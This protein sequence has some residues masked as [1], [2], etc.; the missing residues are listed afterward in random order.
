MGEFRMGRSRAAASYPEPRFTGLVGPFARNVAVGPGSEVN[1]APGGTTISWVLIESTGA[2]GTNVPI[3]PK[4]AIASPSSSNVA[5]EGVIGLHNIGVAAQDVTV[6]VLVNGVALP[7]PAIDISIPSA[8]F[9]E[10]PILALAALPV[11][12]TANITVVVTGDAS[13]NI[14]NFGSILNVYQPSPTTG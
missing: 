1:A 4:V 7:F 8:S 13:V 11:G 6:Q 9:A 14:V 10:L 5:I 12:V 2:A 3:T